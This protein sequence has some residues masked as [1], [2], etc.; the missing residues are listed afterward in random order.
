M[1]S[2][3][4]FF[5]SVAS[6]VAAEHDRT[7][8]GLRGDVEPVPARTRAVAQVT[9]TKDEKARYMRVAQ[10]HGIALSQMVRL[11]LDFYIKQ[12]GWDE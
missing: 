4:D 8:D 9:M 12:M 6:E 10:R 2:D 11:A 5:A 7:R 3:I 1:A